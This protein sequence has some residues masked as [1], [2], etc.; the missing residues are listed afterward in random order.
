M[1]VKKKKKKPYS[2]PLSLILPTLPE[3]VPA[4]VTVSLVKASTFKLCSRH[5]YQLHQENDSLLYEKHKQVVRLQFDGKFVTEKHPIVRMGEKKKACIHENIK[6]LWLSTYK[7]T[8]HFI[9]HHS[10][11]HQRGLGICG[12]FILQPPAFLPATETTDSEIRGVTYRLQHS[13]AQQVT[14]TPLRDKCYDGGYELYLLSSNCVR[15]H[16]NERSMCHMTLLLS[17]VK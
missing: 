3:T 10:F 7:S 11:K 1:N 8:L 17:K 2:K 15:S 9:K 14:K 6:S 12:V 13:R 4:A 5:I 16:K